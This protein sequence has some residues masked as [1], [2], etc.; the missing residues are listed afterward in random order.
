MADTTISG[1]GTAVTAV[2]G[3][4]LFETEQASTTKK[5]T[6]YQLMEFVNDKGSNTASAGTL[7]LGDG[8]YFHITGTST[9][10]DIDFTTPWD[11]R[12]ALLVFDSSLIL[13]HNAT[14]LILPGGAN[15]KTGPGDTCTIVV[16]SGDNVKVTEF[17]R[18]SGVPNAN[19]ANASV[20]NQ[21][22]AASATTLLTGSLINIPDSG[23]QVGTRFLWHVCMSKTAAGT[24]ALQF[25]V[26][27][28]TAGTTSDGTVLNFTFPA[29]GTGVIDQGEVWI[30]FIVAGPLTSSCVPRGVMSF[31][32]TLTTTGFVTTASWIRVL[33]TA[34]NFNA[35]TAALKAHLSIV[36]GASYV[37]TVEQVSVETCNL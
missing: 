9:I 2:A 36:T 34:T 10:T 35:T 29:V 14:T 6:A 33:G 37:I 22:P 18:A 21:S 23:V 13:T 4:D 20:A 30:E 28:G 11:G 26:K 19:P 12:T 24:V 25:L 3:S 1:I 31:S 15:I 17:D 8:S 32:H 16:D 27:V 7:V 5:T